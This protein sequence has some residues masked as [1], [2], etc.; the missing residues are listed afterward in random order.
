MF[1]VA[2]CRDIAKNCRR[3]AED[4]G[5]APRRATILRNIAHS[6]SGLAHQLDLLADDE[7]ALRRSDLKK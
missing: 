4:P 3:L 1:T 2:G 6:L 7:E 5:L